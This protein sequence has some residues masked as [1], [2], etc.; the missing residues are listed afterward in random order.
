M[1]SIIITAYKNDK[2]LIEALNSVVQSAKNVNFEI[3]LG[4]DNCQTTIDGIIKNKNLLPKELRIFY[5]PKVGTYVIRNTLVKITNFENIIFFDSD[6]IMSE[7]TIEET[8]RILKNNDMVKYKYCLFHHNF[9]PK[10]KLLKYPNGFPVGC[11]GI[12]KTSFL[13]LNG[14]EPWICAADGEFFWRAGAN[15]F[16]I[17]PTN[18]LC[19]YHRRH[20]ENLTSNRAT[21]MKSAL[22]Q[23]YHKIK[24]LK[25]KKN[26]IETLEQLHIVGFMEININ[27]FDNFK[28]NLQNHKF[29]NPYREPTI[30]EIKN[31]NIDFKKIKIQKLNEVFTNDKKK[32]SLINYNI[33]N[34]NNKNQIVRPTINEKTTKTLNKKNISNWKDRFGNVRKNF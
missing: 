2:F 1:I 30:H 9:D 3:L 29:F 6:D 33:L 25:I 21:G 22:R 15:N 10:S 14:F 5:F 31:P 4:I 16:K 20:K 28:K 24:N 32:I 17:I 7:F 11:F 34:K 18:N 23:Y 13:R 19:L 12:K 8:I 26:L 27:E